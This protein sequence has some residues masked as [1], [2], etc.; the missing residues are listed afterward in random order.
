MRFVKASVVVLAF[1]VLMLLAVT[2][3]QAAA[4]ARSLSGNRPYF[5]TAS[6]EV[7]AWRKCQRQS[8][9]SVSE[10]SGKSCLRRAATS[11]EGRFFTMKLSAHAENFLKRVFLNV[12]RREGG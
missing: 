11:Q 5:M 4:P 2:S 3:T 1:V 10:M 12:R 6:S 8:F 9:Q 7:T